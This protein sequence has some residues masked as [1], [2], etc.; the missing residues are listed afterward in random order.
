MNRLHN[1]MVRI[2]R[3]ERL[4]KE[5]ENIEAEDVFFD[6]PLKKSVKEFAVL[7]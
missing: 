2:A 4:A 5:N 6:N 7:V 1:L 3:L